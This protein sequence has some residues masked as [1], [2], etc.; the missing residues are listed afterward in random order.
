MRMWTVVVV[1]LLGLVGCSDP[2]SVGLPCVI[3]HPPQQGQQVAETPALDCQARICVQLSTSQPALCT[4]ECGEI[5]EGCT[6]ESNALCEGGEF[7][8]QVPFLVGPF[9]GRHLCVCEAFY[10]EI[11]PSAP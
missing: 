10:Q 8:C 11:R 5:G 1:V 9:A 6:P 4:A 7:R 2:Q 3:Q